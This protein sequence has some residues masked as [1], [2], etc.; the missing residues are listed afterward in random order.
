[1]LRNRR[2]AGIVTGLAL[3]LVVVL[4]G[5]GATEQTSTRPLETAAPAPEASATASRPADLDGSEWNL[6]TLNGADLLPGTNITLGF[7]EG[8]PPVSRAATRT[9]DPILRRAIAHCRSLCW[10]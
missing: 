10:R 9:A 5:C 4:V 7:A 6:T 1:M 8:R 2:L 3:V